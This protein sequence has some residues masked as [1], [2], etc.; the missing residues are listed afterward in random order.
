MR[1]EVKELLENNMLI[2]ELKNDLCEIVDIK[3]RI[4]YLNDLIGCLYVIVEEEYNNYFEVRK[5]DE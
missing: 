4:G 5:E 3:E 1:K 2:E